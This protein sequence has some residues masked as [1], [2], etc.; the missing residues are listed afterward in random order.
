MYALLERVA[1][2]DLHALGFPWKAAWTPVETALGASIPPR[3][4]RVKWHAATRT[5]A[6]RSKRIV[7]ARPALEARV[8]K[9]K[10]ACDVLLR[11]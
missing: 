7:H 2:A 10:L 3:P 1:P 4:V 9:L 11:E 8:R 6:E 5:L